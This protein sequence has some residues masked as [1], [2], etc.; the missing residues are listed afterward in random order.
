METGLEKRYENGVLYIICS[1]ICIALFSLFAKESLCIQSMTLLIF[2]RFAVPCAILLP[3]MLWIKTPLRLSLKKELPRQIIRCCFVLGSQYSLFY[4]LTKGSLLNAMLLY[5]SGT[6]FLPV[7]TWLFY[8]HRVSHK[9]FSSIL[10]SFLGVACILKPSL[11]I[12]SLYALIGLMSG[13]FM[14]F[15]QVFNANNS[16]IDKVDKNLFYFFTLST[17]LSF[18]VFFGVEM[19]T[20]ENIF[21]AVMQDF[22]QN[23][24]L[25]WYLLALGLASILNQL[26]RCMAYSHSRPTS[27][28]PFLYGG[29]VF[30]GFFDWYAF[31]VT[32]DVLS[33][34]GALFVV[35][36]AIMKLKLEMKQEQQR[37]IKT[38]TE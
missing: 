33:L 1:S 15:S 25:N 22:T 8:N 5:N 21:A 7:I 18:L 13:I 36:G 20:T 19:A 34:M 26:F 32:P 30:S 2:F 4:Y 23:V 38:Q 14:A 9:S 31:N 24:K 37:K 6:I 12:V 17:I 11:S 10:I 3:V 29:V 27:L 28:A 35:I 16:T